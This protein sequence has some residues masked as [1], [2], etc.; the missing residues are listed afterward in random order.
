MSELNNNR[1][2][3]LMNAP[4]GMKGYDRRGNEITEWPG[5]DCEIN[6]KHCPWNPAEAKR[7]METGHFVYNENGIRS[8]HFNTL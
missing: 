6:C 7:R 1:S 3:A 4:C 8:L 2:K 5:V